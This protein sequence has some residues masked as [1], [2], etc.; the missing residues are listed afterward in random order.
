MHAY[1]CFVLAALAPAQQPLTAR[2]VVE[3]IKQNIGVPWT[4]PT[5]DTFKDGDSTTRVTGVAVTMMATFD[6][7]QRAAAGGANLVITHE[8]TFYDHLDKL[9]GLEAEDDPVTAGKRDFI[10][11]HHEVVVRMP[12]HWQ[13]RPP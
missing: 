11:Q 4:E 1:L 8:P 12:A 5:V 7:L 2:D 9:H 6:V 10:R 3:R 13:P